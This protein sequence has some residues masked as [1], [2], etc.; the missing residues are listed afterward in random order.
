MTS[1]FELCRVIIISF[2]GPHFYF[3]D[4]SHLLKCNKA[5]YDRFFQDVPSES[6]RSG[7]L[8][9]FILTYPRTVYFRDR[10]PKYVGYWFSFQS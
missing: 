3:D 5:K 2:S 10:D 7:F 6:F 1:I 4:L 8:L 9:L